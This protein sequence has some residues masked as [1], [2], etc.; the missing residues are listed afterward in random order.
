MTGAMLAGALVGVGLFLLARALFPARPGLVARM[1]AFDAA[2]RRDLEEAQAGR[3]SPTLERVGGLRTRVGR[4]LAHYCEIRGWKLQSVRADLAITERSLEGFLATK[5]LLPAAALVF[6]PVIVGYFALLGAGISFQVPVWICAFF[7]VLFFFFPDLQLRQEAAARR[8]DFRHVVG[9]FLDL[10]SMNLA[11]GRGVPEALMTAS[12]VGEG[13]AM[14]RLRDA[15]AN[16]RITGHTPWQAL[17]RLGDELDIAELRDL[18]GAL[19]LVADDGAQIRKSLTARAASMRSRELS[20]LEG[21]AGERSQSMLVAQLLIC[22]AFLVFLA[23][24]ALMRVI[25]A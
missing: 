11:G 10:V 7:A 12:N 16:A 3:M 8:Q 19:A 24:P 13:W 18:A 5:F 6:I 25:S 9:A 23:Y 2:R 15:L 22:A 20:E 4:E 14:T 17:G 1:A 21:K